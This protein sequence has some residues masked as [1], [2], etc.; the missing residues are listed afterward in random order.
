M[1]IQF[2]LERDVEIDVL[3]VGASDAAFDA[4]L[5]VGC[6]APAV[7]GRGA[8]LPQAC[9]VLILNPSHKTGARRTKK[10]DAFPGGAASD[11]E[12]LE[13]TGQV[14]LGEKVPKPAQNELDFAPPVADDEENEGFDE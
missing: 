14:A 13:T 1:L 7:K 9:R 12:T 5:N 4:V 3:G 11:F 2:G 10:A 6:V 8:T